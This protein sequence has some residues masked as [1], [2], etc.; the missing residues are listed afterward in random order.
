MAHY[1]Y[2]DAFMNVYV[3]FCAYKWSENLNGT[4]ESCTFKIPS[5]GEYNT[6]YW[7]LYH[8]TGIFPV[9]SSN[10]HDSKLWL[11]LGQA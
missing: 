3:C 2:G 4:I 10:M 6:S 5:T 11:S 8:K 7:Q 1:N 9:Q